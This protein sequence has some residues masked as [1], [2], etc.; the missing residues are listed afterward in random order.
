MNFSSAARRIIRHIGCF[1]TFRRF[2]NYIFIAGVQKGG[3]T[4]LYSYLVRHPLIVGSETKELHFFDREAEYRKGFR[5]YNSRFPFFTKASHALEAT[6]NY[7]YRENVALRIHSY[8]PGAKIIAVLREPVLRA[9]SAFNMYQQ[10]TSLASFNGMIS[11][12]NQDSKDF[13]GGLASGNIELT[14]ESFLERE[15][16][17]INNRQAAEEPGLIRRGIYAPQ[18]ARYFDL[19]GRENVLVLFS[20]DLLSEPERV[21]NQVL[22][23][24]GLSPLVG[25]DY[26]KMHVREYGVDS[27]AKEMIRLRA[28]DFFEKDKKE[29]QD[30]FG[31][32]VPW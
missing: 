13:F 22:E 6:P 29:L 25:L 8:R 10:I 4:S 31:I 28:G 20:E 27:A 19:F 30:R 9:Y 21:T 11:N 23:F 32:V 5:Y 17:I 26:P 15:L 3:T 2:D 12:A 7:L 24:V 18:L 16:E 14:I 1:L